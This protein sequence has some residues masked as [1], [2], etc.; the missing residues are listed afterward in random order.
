MY[1]IDTE[2]CTRVKRNSDTIHGYATN[3]YWPLD[4][5]NATT[6]ISISYFLKTK[7]WLKRDIIYQIKMLIFYFLNYYNLLW[8]FFIAYSIL[9]SNSA[10]PVLLRYMLFWRRKLFV[11]LGQQSLIF[12]I[13]LSNCKK[14][15]GDESIKKS[16]FELWA[17][18]HLNWTKPVR[19]IK[20]KFSDL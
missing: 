15:R 4:S 17:L 2:Y 10:K 7:N 14:I 18:R 11:K 9:L 6:H 19:Y 1:L 5:T 8:N 13:P 12:Q 16:V 20:I 3:V